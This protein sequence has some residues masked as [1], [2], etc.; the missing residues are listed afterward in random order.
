[1][2]SRYYCTESWHFKSSFSKAHRRVSGE[3]E[4]GHNQDRQHGA[5]LGT[6][7]DG[8][9]GVS[10]HQQ[11]DTQSVPSCPRAEETIVLPRQDCEQHISRALLARHAEGLGEE[12]V[13][14]RN[15]PKG[16]QHKEIAL[17]VCQT[18]EHQDLLSNVKADLLLLLLSSCPKFPS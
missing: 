10:R 18:T 11:G 16:S 15:P 13:P 3:P 2:K 17:N 5:V 1:M 12:T 9:C 14:Q 8:H 7:Q 4:V 6:C